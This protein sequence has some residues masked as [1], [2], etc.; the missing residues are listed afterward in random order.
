[1]IGDDTARD[2]QQPRP[3]TGS[4]GEPLDGA[5][6]A[7]IGFLGQVIGAARVRQVGDKP[8]HVLLRGLD[9]RLERSRVPPR[10]GQGEVGNG[11]VVR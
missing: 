2:G 3:G 8:P 7:E 10:G 9:E 6:G 11:L 4:S 1:M 5:E